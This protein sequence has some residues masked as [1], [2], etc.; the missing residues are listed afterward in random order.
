MES[1]K[2]LDSQITASSYKTYYEPHQARL[3]MTASASGNGA[4]CAS[5]SHQRGEWL[6]VRARSL[7]V[8]LYAHWRGK[9]GAGREGNNLIELM[10]SLPLGFFCHLDCETIWILDF[11]FGTLLFS[12]LK[13]CELNWRMIHEPIPVSYLGNFFQFLFFTTTLAYCISIFA[14]KNKQ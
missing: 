5:Q 11:F 1:N 13:W 3:H 6:Q 9:G 10:D 7:F 8:F 2:I 14:S 12:V 4:W